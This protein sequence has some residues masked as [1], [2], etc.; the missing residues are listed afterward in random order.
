MTYQ[1]AFLAGCVEGPAVLDGIR[2]ALSRHDV[3]PRHDNVRIAMT[4][5]SGGS[6][7]SGWAAHFAPNYAP[8]LNIVGWVAGGLPADLAKTFAYNDGTVSSGLNFLGLAGLSA[9]YPKLDKYV[10]SH[11]KSNATAVLDRITG[12]AGKKGAFC[13]SQS[14]ELA[15]LTIADSFNVKNISDAAIVRQTW[16][17]EYLGRYY[18][19]VTDFPIWLVHSV[20]DNVV[21]YPQA[22]EYVQNQCTQGA[23]ITFVSLPTGAH[24]AVQVL[25]SASQVERLQY[26][27]GQSGSSNDDHSCRY[28]TSLPVSLNDTSAKDL[29]GDYGFTL[30]QQAIAAAM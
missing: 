20:E 9:V 16:Y 21:P 4:G 5:Y 2:A 10:R 14:A 1:S 28:K 19:P 29:L 26:F 7:G 15:N 18:A 23:E 11:A 6:H 24:G 13:V 25:S 27:L 3:I 22:K 30:I 17:D 8:E 12:E